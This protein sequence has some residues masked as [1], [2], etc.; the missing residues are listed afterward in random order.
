MS[1]SE[2]YKMNRLACF[3]LVIV[4]VIVCACSKSPTDVIV[5]GA[6]A[7]GH[8]IMDPLVQKDASA[9]AERMITLVIAD[10]PECEIYK[11]HMREAGKGSPYDATTQKGFI[12]TQQ[13]ACKAGCC[14]HG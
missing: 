14:K 2:V 9:Q 10:K 4:A 5:D 12:T 11:T 6:T 3:P 13:E 8:K 7:A 1:Q